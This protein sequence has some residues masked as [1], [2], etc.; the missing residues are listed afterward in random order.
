MSH[1]LTLLQVFQF[2]LL[3]RKLGS[4]TMEPLRPKMRRRQ[5]EEGSLLRQRYQRHKEQSR[6]P[7][8]LAAETSF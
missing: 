8:L 1:N 6:R 4:G 2:L 7:Q 5:A 3:K